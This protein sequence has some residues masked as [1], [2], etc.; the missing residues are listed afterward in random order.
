MRESAQKFI[1]NKHDSLLL[2]KATTR[3]H[4]VHLRKLLTLYHLS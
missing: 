3:V 2:I 4:E 1:T